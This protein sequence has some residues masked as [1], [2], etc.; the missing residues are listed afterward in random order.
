M[1]AKQWRAL[2]MYG[3]GN[4]SSSPA[5]DLDQMLSPVSDLALNGYL[6]I[7]AEETK[8]SG[9]DASC[10]VL[11]CCCPKKLVSLKHISSV[12]HLVWIDCHFVF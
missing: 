11:V 1:V 4:K 6:V 12:G 3:S 8:A 10:V 2:A 5:L 7:Q 9:F